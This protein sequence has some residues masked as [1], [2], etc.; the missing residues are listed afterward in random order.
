MQIQSG[1]SIANQ[2][3]KVQEAT[4]KTEAA[5]AVAIAKKG[6]DAQKQQGEAIVDLIQQAGRGIKFKRNETLPCHFH[7]DDGPIQ[8]PAW[9]ESHGLAFFACPF[10]Q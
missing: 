3:I 2:M 4:S 6:L 9:R 8:E 5:V 1:S 10:A 7:L